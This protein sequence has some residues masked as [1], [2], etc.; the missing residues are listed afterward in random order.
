MM[1]SLEEEKEKW[2]H[3]QSIIRLQNERERV[4]QLAVQGRISEEIASWRVR[5]INQ[6]I[7]S[8]YNEKEGVGRYE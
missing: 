5:E 6:E 1:E 7:E 3:N 8:V 2:K 4:T